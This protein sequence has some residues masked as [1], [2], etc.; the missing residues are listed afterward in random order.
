M[1]KLALL[2]IPHDENSSY[3]RGPA[4]APPL[5]RQELH[6]DAYSIWTETGIDLGVEGRLVDHGDIRFD[7]MADPWDVIEQTVARTLESG[8]PLISLGG[9]HA[10]THPILRAV[11]KRHPKLTIIHID[12]HSDIYH[13]YQDN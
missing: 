5:I 12:A 3:K 9:D 2:G 6:N 8:D 10:I 13:A 4:E 7:G 1:V 11:R